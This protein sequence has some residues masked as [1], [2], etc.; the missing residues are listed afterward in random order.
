MR[1]ERYA[2]SLVFIFVAATAG[3]ATAQTFPSRP[4]SLLQYTAP[5]DPGD[6]VAR[7]IQPRLVERLGQPWVIESRPGAS[8]A[9]ATQAVARATPDGHTLLL[10]LSG[11]V[12]N[13][14]A[15]QKLPY[16]TVRDFAG[17][18]LLVRQP[19]IVVVHPSVKGSNLR[20]FIDAAKAQPPGS[21][22]FSSPG[23]ATLTVL[24]CEEISRRAG[25]GI[26]H[27]PFKGGGPAIQALL[28]N[29]VQVS[30]LLQAIVN[31]HIKSGRLKPLAVTSI[32]RLPELPEVPTLMESGFG[33]GGIYNWIGIFAPAATPGAV[34]ARLNAEITGALADPVI[35]ARLT[36][37]G[38]EIV[39][40]APQELDR[41]VVSEI[42][43][44]QKFVREFDVRFE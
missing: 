11:H 31:P 12:V 32:A 39:G 33:A 30:A 17:V 3:V 20:E 44:W 14:S 23:T 22:A 29:Q 40:S 10:A 41:F 35:R 37:A 27:A 4:V 15:N 2:R 28:A 25:L 21:L 1:L 18:S 42:E 34:L 6:I 5:G 13:P 24:I 36:G 19:L 38:F 43:R 16:D 9:I 8:G 26:L 7:L